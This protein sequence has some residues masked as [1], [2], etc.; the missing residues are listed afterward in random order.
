MEKLGPAISCL[1]LLY[2]TV[3]G[4]CWGEIKCYSVACLLATVVPL[5]SPGAVGGSIRCDYC[6]RE[7]VNYQ[8]SLVDGTLDLLPADSFSLR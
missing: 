3:D 6:S 4:I 5:K 2:S 1:V 7:T 8:A